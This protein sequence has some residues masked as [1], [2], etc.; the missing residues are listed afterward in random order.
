MSDPLME[1]FLGNRPLI[2]HNRKRIKAP[3]EIPKDT[4]CWP[5]QEKKKPEIPSAR[6]VPVPRVPPSTRRRV[7]VRRGKAAIFKAKVKALVEFYKPVEA[8]TKKR[9]QK[10]ATAGIQKGGG[11]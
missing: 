8:W 2:T 4:H 5:E 10:W 11:S 6:C 9:N 1:L 3:A 7:L